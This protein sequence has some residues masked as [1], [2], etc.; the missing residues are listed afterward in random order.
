[1]I[2][3]EIP[4]DF[5]VNEVIDLKL[6]KEINNYTIFKLTKKNWDAFKII[7]SLAKA[8][9]IKS[10]LIGFAGNK[11]K[12]AIT[13]QYISFFKIPR[14][15]IENIKINDVKLEFQGYSV[16]RINLGDLKGNS[17]VIVVRDL[18]N[19]KDLPNKIYLENYFDDQR[20]GN[21]HNTHLVGKA[22]VK[23][24]FKTAC[25]LLN[26]QT[27]NNDYIGALRSQQRRLLRFYLSSYQSLIFNKILSKY[28]ENI[29]HY[30]LEYSLG[31]LNFTDSKNKKIKIPLIG[32]DVKLT[33]EIK[34]IAEGILKEEGVSIQDFLIRSLPELVTESAYRPAFLEVKDIKYKFDNDELHKDKLKCTVT[35]SLTKGAYATLLIKKL[36]R[37]LV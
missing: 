27:K 24:D 25:L 20:F 21:K 28:L 37:Y 1:M 2:I 36:E 35:F 31:K 7:E 26:L 32:F 11:D 4:E 23:K 16:E 18:I 22:L 17:F 33:K 19:K 34:P 8:L 5:V 29:E 10:K 3:K 9:I 15:R 6:T 14:E 12:Q 30:Q 13:S